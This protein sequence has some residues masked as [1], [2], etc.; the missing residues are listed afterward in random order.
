MFFV[1]SHNAQHYQ[2]RSWRT[3]PAKVTI[4]DAQDEKTPEDVPADDTGE[5]TGED[6]RDTGDDQFQT[7]WY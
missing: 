2:I 3:F 6:T 4:P 5:D 7:P 1:C